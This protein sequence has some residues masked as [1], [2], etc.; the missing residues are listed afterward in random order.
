MTVMCINTGG[1]VEVRRL[2]FGL[3]EYVVPSNG[4]KFGDFLE[5]THIRT[6]F[7][8]F[9]E[10]PNEEYPHQYFIRVRDDDEGDAPLQPV[11]ELKY[12]NKW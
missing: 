10:W 11:P 9:E 5:V 1:W 2:F 4:P 8:E 12:K 6:R 3:W 7:Y